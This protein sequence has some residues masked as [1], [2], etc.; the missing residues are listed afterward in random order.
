MTQEIITN[1]L[2]ALQ[3]NE[4]EVIVKQF[5][6]WNTK[7][8]EFLIFFKPEIF[9]NWNPTLIEKSVNL[10]FDKLAQND[11]DVSWAILFKWD[12]LRELEI[13]DRHYGFINYI[14][15]NASKLPQE[16][17]NKIYAT[18]EITDIDNYK[19][20]GWHE[21]LA[22][23]H[24]F[25]EE[26]LD[27]LWL[28]KKSA[29]VRSGFYVQKYELNWNNIILVNAFHP[30]QL[31][32]YTDSSHKT[33]VVLCNSNQNWAELKDK[34]AGDTFPEKAVRESIRWE[35]YA[36]KEQYWLD[37]VSISF[38]CVHMSA[39]PFEAL[40]EIN[41]F[42]KQAKSA[43]YDISK[44]NLYSRLSKAGISNDSIINTLT[45]PKVEINGKLTSLFDATENN[46]TTVS[47]DIFRGNYL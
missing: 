15:K 19:V 44:T 4:N 5:S 28:T 27:T 21:F 6:F 2:N 7:E 14:S 9:I 17:L 45:N 22:S 24:D 38:N 47:V 33:L 32:H 20:Y 23:H 31:K 3:S 12:R 30:V 40:F 34:V 37:D 16:D 42:L 11:I 1:T 41:N 18:L 39:G 8:N 13:M 36:N 43:N 26:S 46:W 29:K 25:T 35:F 10:V